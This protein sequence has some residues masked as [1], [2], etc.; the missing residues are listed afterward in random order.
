[1]ADVFPDVRQAPFVAGAANHLVLAAA[2]LD[3]DRLPASI[4][5]EVDRYLNQTVPGLR[6]VERT[7]DKVY[8]DDRT[9]LELLMAN[10][11]G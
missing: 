3:L 2:R 6:P 10:P 7:S 5:P 8:T 1:V 4:G 11:H 9:D